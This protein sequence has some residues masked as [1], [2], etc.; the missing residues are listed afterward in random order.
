MN[1]S[2][3]K[4][5]ERQQFQNN[6]IITEIQQKQQQQINQQKKDNQQKITT[7]TNIK[8]QETRYRSPN[9]IQQKFVDFLSIDQL[10]KKL[11]N[12][13]DIVQFFDEQYKPLYNEYLNVKDILIEHQKDTNGSFD[14]VI[15]QLNQQYQNA[16]MSI[17]LKNNSIKQ[18]EEKIKNHSEQ[19]NKIQMAHN[20]QIAEL[21]ESIKQTI[22]KN[23]EKL[24][25]KDIEID[26]ANK[27]NQDSRNQYKQQV[28]QKLKGIKQE[29][30]NEKNQLL[31]QIQQN[32]QIINQFKQ[33]I[34]NQ[35]EKISKLKE[36]NDSYEEN[37][38]QEKKLMRQNVEKVQQDERKKQKI[39]QQKI[40]ENLVEK[41]EQLEKINLQNQQ[42]IESINLSENLSKNI[43]QIQEKPAKFI[44]NSDLEE[45]LRKYTEEKEGII[46]NIQHLYENQNEDVY[47]IKCTILTILQGIEQKSY[48][49]VKFLQREIVNLVKIQEQKFEKLLSDQK[50]TY[51]K[52][53]QQLKD[54][55]QQINEQNMENMN[56]Q[57]Q[58]MQ[59]LQEEQLQNQRITHNNQEEQQRKENQLLESQL[60]YYKQCVEETC[61]Y[62]NS[63]NQ[64]HLDEYEDYTELVNRL[65]RQNVDL[66]NVVKEMQQE[67]INSLEDSK[68]IQYK[69]ISY[70]KQDQQINVWENEVQEL[71]KKIDEFKV[72]KQEL[73]QLQTFQE[74]NN[75]KETNFKQNREKLKDSY[76]AQ[77]NQKLQIM[78]NKY[79]YEIKKL[80]E[81]KEINKCQ[82]QELKT[83]LKEKILQAKRSLHRLSTLNFNNEI[84]K[85][86]SGQDFNQ[87]IQ[88]LKNQYEQEIQNGSKKDLQYEIS[89]DSDESDYFE[90]EQGIQNDLYLDEKYAL[91]KKIED[92]QQFIIKLE[93]N[94]VDDQEIIRQKQEK[95]QE[96]KDLLNIK[97]KE[98][99]IQCNIDGEEQKRKIDKYFQKNEQI[100]KQ[101]EGM[102]EID[103][104]NVSLVENY[105]QYK[106]KLKQNKG[107][108]VFMQEQKILY[109][110]LKDKKEEIDQMNEKL[111]KEEK[112]WL[113]QM[114][115]K[116]PNQQ[117]VTAI[118]L[119]EQYSRQFQQQQLYKNYLKQQQ[120]HVLR[121]D[122]EYQQVSDFLLE[123]LP[124]TEYF[125]NLK[126]EQQNAFYMEQYEFKLFKQTQA[127]I[128]KNIEIQ[129]EQFGQI[130][131]GIQVQ[132]EFF[133]SYLVESLI[134]NQS[135]LDPQMEKQLISDLQFINKR[136]IQ[137]EKNAKLKDIQVK[138]A[139]INQDKK[140]DFIR[141]KFDQNLNQENQKSKNEL[142]IEKFNVKLQCVPQEE[143]LIESIDNLQKTKIEIENQLN[144]VYAQIEQ[145]QKT[146][147]DINIKIKDQEYKFNKESLLISK[148]L[149]ELKKNQYDTQKEM[150]NLEEIKREKMENLRK[151]IKEKEKEIQ[152]FESESFL[153]GPLSNREKKIIIIQKYRYQQE[154][155]G[156]KSDIQKKQ[157][158]I[159]EIQK[160]YQQVQKQ[161]A[162]IIEFKI[163]EKEVFYF[164]EMD[165]KLSVIDEMKAQ[166]RKMTDAIAQIQNQY[167]QYKIQ[168]LQQ[169]EENEQRNKVLQLEI[170]KKK[171][172]NLEI[173]GQIRQFNKKKLGQDQSID[174]NENQEEIEYYESKIEYLRQ[175][176]FNLIENLES[177]KDNFEQQTELV[178]EI[179]GTKYEIVNQI[180][181][182]QVQEQNDLSLSQILDNAQTQLESQLEI[183]YKTQKIDELKKQKKKN[184]DKENKEKRENK[185][186]D[187]NEEKQSIIQLSE[188]EQQ[189]IA[190]QDNF[191]AKMRLLQENY[192]VPQSRNQSQDFSLRNQLDQNGQNWNKSS[193]QQDDQQSQ[194]EMTQK[195]QQKKITEEEIMNFY[196]ESLQN[197]NFNN[198]LQ[199]GQHEEEND[200]NNNKKK[201]KKLQSYNSL[202]NFSETEFKNI[203]TQ[204]ENS[205]KD[206]QI[207]TVNK[208]GLKID[209]KGN[210]VKDLL[211]ISEFLNEN[212]QGNEEEDKNQAYKNNMQ[213]KLKEMRQQIQKLNQSLEERDK[214]TRDLNNKMQNLNQEIQ[215]GSQDRQDILDYTEFISKKLKKFEKIG[216]NEKENLLQ[217]IAL[218]RKNKD[219]YIQDYLKQE[220]IEENQKIV[221][222][223]QKQQIEKQ[224][225]DQQNKMKKEEYKQY[226]EKIEELQ[227]Q[228]ESQESKLKNL[229]TQINQNK[230]TL[231]D[232]E[233][234]INELQDENKKLNEN[235]NELE[236]KIATFIKIINYVDEKLGNQNLSQM[237]SVE[238]DKLLYRVQYKKQEQEKE[239]NQDQIIQKQ[240]EKNAIY[241]QK[242]F[243]QEKE[244]LEEENKKLRKK[245]KL[246]E[247]KNS[248]QLQKIKTENKNS[249]S[250]NNNDIQNSF[251]ENKLIKENLDSSQF[252][253]SKNKKNR[254]NFVK[255]SRSRSVAGAYQNQNKTQK[256]EN[257][258]NNIKLSPILQQK[259]KSKTIYSD[260]LKMKQEL[261]NNINISQV[262]ESDSTH[263]NQNLN[264]NFCNWKQTAQQ[265]QEKKLKKIRPQQV[266]FMS[267]N[268]SPVR[269]KQQQNSD[270]QGFQELKSQNDQ[271]LKDLNFQ[272]EKDET[273]NQLEING[274]QPMLQDLFEPNQLK[275]LSQ[276]Q[277]QFY[278]KKNSRNTANKWEKL[279]EISKTNFLEH[280]RKDSLEIK[281]K[282][283]QY[284][285]DK[286]HKTHTIEDFIQVSN[287]NS[288]SN[289]QSRNQD[290]SLQ[291]FKKINKLESQQNNNHQSKLY[292]SY[293]KRTFSQQNK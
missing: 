176:N 22:L 254:E 240:E 214:L 102:R 179:K 185:E 156:Y 5:L 278:T 263:R 12:L 89:I 115:Y 101:Y 4:D 100:S 123:S 281:G 205:F 239:K 187:E 225:Q 257:S 193:Q 237:T 290:F 200:D 96:L 198:E 230:L 284:N 270:L 33:Q 191:M 127:N 190:L 180:N 105:N 122:F 48:K 161:M 82:I 292:T 277:Q 91:E 19:Q 160:D 172:E 234:E 64:Q 287:N 242:I 264:Q 111:E 208:E 144:E 72:S 26:I 134:K 63:L 147:D 141:E 14:Q 163:K 106:E 288:N 269:K 202:F 68:E 169:L 232:K 104:E 150:D 280:I 85:N 175:Q 289:N 215:L 266:N 189:L 216:Q 62:L 31:S 259:S 56:K 130:N 158:L 30:L 58:K 246:L 136:I 244:N 2:S 253:S 70:G 209:Q 37:L 217:R 206:Q 39:L 15:D 50:S 60:V 238:L 226:E 276:T 184:K 164:Q 274:K 260:R 201:Q 139:R 262:S 252:S 128:K 133:L 124:Q 51:E 67:S 168:K 24:K 44:E 16:H 76:L 212:D 229:K 251:F 165:N 59:S 29:F 81:D 69:E 267:Q 125:Q 92:Q 75:N 18:M 120:L 258:E 107:F 110:Q 162:K 272:Y 118:S 222:K 40:F 3:Q 218:F 154:I 138:Q 220:E 83:E 159:E 10:K 90:K 79:N 98:V 195:Y 42:K 210:Y 146:L 174:K 233:K 204:T 103:D 113:E 245:I 153:D 291:M 55:Y 188:Q 149:E 135:F 109:Q 166:M 151:E 46:Q 1:N 167:R 61:L 9:K 221:S 53:N 265:F 21:E 228:I 285:L 112:Q 129:T 261:Q 78:E 84:A 173:Q 283:T 32:E 57:I 192:C 52:E 256:R 25:Q 36:L 282:G 155:N 248:Q 236:K 227:K 183:D 224:I 117:G 143:N 231:K 7:S 45:N 77:T 142:Q 94:I 17:D 126:M 47:Q 20:Q 121:K 66:Q 35:N 116:N 27:K 11:L 71:R 140:Y 43:N 28:D 271:F 182:K 152:D 74:Q 23:N 211:E 49:E 241:E 88:Q 99:Q 196:N 286:Q 131:K 6:V 207:Q 275:K 86:Q 194:F 97:K 148:N 171:M 8:P 170:S 54:H 87:K 137:L 108:Q 213:K 13:E 177:L 279:N 243:K 293:R 119:N 145:E 41:L 223:L 235:L 65:T 178:W 157:Q 181:E 255:Y 95:I 73:K 38:N 114:N 247:K 34:E 199:N 203:Q 249:I 250:N 197:I 273:F 132:D 268:N 80:K 186:N 219:K 93:K